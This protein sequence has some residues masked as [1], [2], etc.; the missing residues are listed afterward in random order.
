MS[1]NL[2]F[3]IKGYNLGLN[4]PTSILYRLHF[5]QNPTFFAPIQSNEKLGNVYVYYIRRRNNIDMRNF[6]GILYDFEGRWIT[7]L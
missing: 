3:I 4:I 2:R 7:L 1:M 5:S 6:G